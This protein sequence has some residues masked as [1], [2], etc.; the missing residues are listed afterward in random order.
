MLFGLYL[1]N[2][3]NGFNTA[4]IEALAELMNGYIEVNRGANME[5]DGTKHTA[6][7]E[8]FKGDGQFW[9][10]FPALQTR[11]LSHGSRSDGDRKDLS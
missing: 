3:S 2:K 4:V 7:I 1:N 10:D 11:V 6:L 8:K 9:T 5:N